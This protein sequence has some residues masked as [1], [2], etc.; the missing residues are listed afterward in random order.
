MGVIR[1]TPSGEWIAERQN[2]TAERSD[3]AIPSASEQD[4]SKLKSAL[5]KLKPG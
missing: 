5:G 4:D 3:T 1:R 2:D